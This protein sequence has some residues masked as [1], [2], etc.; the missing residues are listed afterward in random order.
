M[1]QA[2][3]EQMRRFNVVVCH[4]RFGKTVLCVNHLIRA[5]ASCLLPRPRFAYLAPSYRQAKAVA[6]DY[7][8]HFTGP[9]PGA[10]RHEG[11][12]RID[13]PNGARI[14]LLGADNPD[15]LRGLYI[16]GIVFDEYGQMA[17]RIFGEVVRP[18]LAD[19]QGWAI[20]IGTPQGRNGFH[21]IYEAAR[22]DP[23]WFTA[24]HRASETGLIEAEELAAARR[25]MTPEEYAQEFECS[26]EAAAAGSY[27]GR[28]IEAAAAEG[29]IAAVPC[30][31]RLPVHTAWD[32]SMDDSTAIWFA[33]AAG[34]EVRL[35]GYYEASGEGLE[36]YVRVL[37]QRGFVYG[38][39]WLPHDA[40]VREL[41]TGV[42]RIETL[43]SLGLRA[44]V[45]PAL[46]IED[47]VNAARL[48]L[49]RCWFDRDACAA[50]LAAL[51]HYRRDY[52]EKL[53]AY[54]ARPVHDWSSHGADAFRY[55]A[56]GLAQLRDGARTLPKRDKGWVV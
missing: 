32:L 37:Q 29:R 9:I 11:E 36:H 33:Q 47:G 55:L 40:E 35:V 10:L 12:L 49:P 27:Y 48:L 20:F 7:L 50:G 30:D 34:A 19:R 17:P 42:S 52:D 24:L 28:L 6:W 53:R 26:F 18:A 8:K 43:A 25:V 51:R 1:Q 44:R 3:H 45:L 2:L 31:P 22:L 21:E 56:V 23:D 39:H 5:A 54:R 15:A 46:R 16:D 4:R 13:L 14:A 41:G 38:E